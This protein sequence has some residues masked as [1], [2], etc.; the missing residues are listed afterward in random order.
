M[1]IIACD[2][3]VSRCGWGRGGCV[4]NFGSTELRRRSTESLF[5]VRVPLTVLALTLIA[6]PHMSD[7][8]PRVVSDVSVGVYVGVGV[9]VRSAM[10]SAV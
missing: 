4:N 5:G 2:D 1:S 7:I 10:G 3:L 8:D 9:E 6:G